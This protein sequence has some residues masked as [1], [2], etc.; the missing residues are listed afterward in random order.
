[1]EGGGGGD[2][3]LLLPLLFPFVSYNVVCEKYDCNMVDIFSLFLGK[4][5]KDIEGLLVD[6]YFT[7]EVHLLHYNSDH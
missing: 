1:M 5:E 6:L 4:W 7:C 3:G 2:L